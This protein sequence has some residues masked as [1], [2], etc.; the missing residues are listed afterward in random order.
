MRKS[1]HRSG[2][3]LHALGDTDTKLCHRSLRL[4]RVSRCGTPPSGFHA[5]RRS[6][7]LRDSDESSYAD[8]R[9]R[10]DSLTSFHANVRSDFP[11]DVIILQAVII[12]KIVGKLTV[13]EPTVRW[14]AAAAA[15]TDLPVTSAPSVPQHPAGGGATGLLGGFRRGYRAYQQLP[16]RAQWMMLAY[17]AV[18]LT[19]LSPSGLLT[20]WLSAEGVS[21]KCTLL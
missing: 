4:Q 2:Y 18:Y 17:I 3:L 10:S 12:V 16:A 19:V 9:W 11:N 15:T 13:A 20:A 14:T 6:V 21:N 7:A 8:R 1:A 5:D